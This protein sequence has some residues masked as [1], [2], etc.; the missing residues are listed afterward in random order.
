MAADPAR[1]LL[2][3]SER[4]GHAGFRPDIQ[5]LRAVAVGAVLLYHANWSLFGGGFIGVDVFFVISGFLITGILLREAERTGRIR[6]A[7]FYAKRARR[8]LPAATVVL[9]VTLAL[10]VA[11]LP[12]IRWE[13]IGIEAIASAF[14]VVN[15]VFA[16]GTD[17]LNAD[18]AASPLQHFWTLAVEEQ[19]YIVW[20]LVLVA[21]LAVFVR[22]THADAPDGHATATRRS[23]RI[24]VIVILVPSLLYSVYATATEPATAYF[25]TTTRLWEL[26]IG[27][28]LAVF[29]PQV[30]RIPHWLGTMLGWL[31][32][33][34]IAAAAVLFTGAMPFPGAAALVPTLGAAAVIAGGMNGRAQ[35]GAGRVLTL[36][37][38]RWIGD[39]SYSLYLWHWPL[40]V[41]G[42]YLL[43][44]E[45]RVR[46][47]LLIVVFSVLPAWLSYRFIENP[48]RTWTWVTH[49]ARRALTAGAGM[50]ASTA[51]VATLV[52]FTPTMM[53]P[54]YRADGDP[55]G[56]EALTD[57]FTD[58]DPASFTDAGD[59]VDEVEGGFTP[60]AINAREDNTIVYELGCNRPSTSPTPKIDGC[61]F[62]DTDSDV[63]IVLIGDS[64]AAN[65]AS[66]YIEL[67]EQNGWRLWVTSKA[68]CG[69]ANVSQADRNGDEYTS[70]NAWSAASFDQILAE[71]PDLVVTANRGTRAAYQEGLSR[72]E[73]RLRYADGLRDNLQLLAD[74][75]IPSLIMN[76]TPSMNSDV[77]ECI[78]EHPD[79]LT[80]CATPR[81]D[82]FG[83]GSEYV[84]YTVEGLAH[85]DVI[86]MTNW[87]CPD[88]DACA[89][90]IGNVVVYRDP[91]HFTETFSRTLAE[92]LE[93]QLRES[94]VARAALWGADER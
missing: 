40:I 3:A 42:T 10:T 16:A 84:A 65:W 68:S 41:V 88:T 8:I 75:G 48:F 80:E 4:S 78:S 76:T 23:A 61:I 13:S 27:A 39:I 12:Q 33:V 49:S 1:A 92:P 22:V 51:V 6:L 60:S 7:D 59:P 56:A 81:E 83:R 93:A 28:A 19:F 30:G 26:A 45:L 70:C 18:V 64:H 47:G 58:D 53:N 37:P 46:Y 36:R 15:W 44:G 14:Y 63:S 11:L 89:A 50:M 85:T 77:P 94:D 66:T 91:H 57:D 24:G 5:G 86:D 74:A 72:Q 54:E 62:G 32:L 9:L 71:Q 90:V 2:S 21:L 55:I 35:T 31:G 87:I 79:Q 82:A 73:M 25:V 38:M 52:V 69:F 34:A 20:P 67:A 17:Y 29:A 43:G